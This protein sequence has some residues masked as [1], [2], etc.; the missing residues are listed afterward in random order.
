M[1]NFKRISY[2]VAYCGIICALSLMIMMISIIPGFNYAIPAVSGIFIWSICFFISHKWALLSFAAS[3]LLSLM[4]IPEIEARTVY[5]AFFG[6]YPI[7]RDKLAVIKPRVLRFPVKLAVFNASCIASYHIL[8]AII[9]LDR[10]LEGMDFAG[11]MAVYVFWGA[12][13]FA[14][15]CYELCLSQLGYVMEKWIKPRFMKRVNK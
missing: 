2:K 14:F 6:Y 15:L 7:L 12:A 4:L 10:V 5:I 9:G 13:N 11:E 8:V 3:A 1:G